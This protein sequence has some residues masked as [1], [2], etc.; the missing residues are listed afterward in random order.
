MTFH[1]ISKK[2]QKLNL[3]LKSF[4]DPNSISIFKNKL[5]TKGKHI[6]KVSLKDLELGNYFLEI[7][8]E[9]GEVLARHIFVKVENNFF[10]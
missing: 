9:R 3:A 7:K 5:F 1:F 6:S 10:D 2:N 4:I 8:N